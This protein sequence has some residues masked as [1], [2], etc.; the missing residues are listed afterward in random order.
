MVSVEGRNAPI[1]LVG[2]ALIPKYESRAPL[3]HGV[4]LKSLAVPLSVPVSTILRFD[5][6]TEPVGVS[7]LSGTSRSMNS[8]PELGPED[9]VNPNSRGGLKGVPEF[10]PL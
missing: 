7:N 2:L 5:G 1:G 4:L 9:D 6:I 10:M 8:S 3:V